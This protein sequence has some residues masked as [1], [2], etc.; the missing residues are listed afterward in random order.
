MGERRRERRGSYAILYGVSGWMLLGFGALAID[1]GMI[2]LAQSQSQDVADAASQGALLALRATGDAAKATTIA[3]AVAA[4]NRVSG[5]APTLQ[6]IRFGVWQDGAF[7]EDDER[8]NAVQVE[9]GR[10]I[11]LALSR[12]WGYSTFPVSRSSTSAARTLEVIL[13]MDI[14]NSWSQ[15][16]FSNARLA[17]LE[18]YDT[19]AN[20]AGPEDRIGM[21]LFSGQ[22]GVEYTP[23]YTIPEA[24]A[25]GVRYDWSVLRTASK[26]GTPSTNSNGCNVYTGASTND[27]S[28]PAGGCFPQMWREYADESGTDHTTGLEMAKLMFEEQ[29]DPSVYRALVLLTDGEPNG[30]GAHAQRAAAGFVDDRWR[31]YKTN[32]RRNT[33]AVISESQSLAETMQ[34]ELDV[35]IWAISFVASASWMNNVIQGD[36]Y[37]VQTS[38]SNALAGIFEDIAEGLPVAVVQ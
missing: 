3:E 29:D 19:I 1:I 32:I 8:P 7:S 17:A 9:V 12:I 36:G 15:A 23:L 10:P 34:E 14:T 27:F 13:V 25:S 37:F 30:T 2:R 26:A 11:D 35:N 24:E 28:S 4:N 18:F 31:W 16:N 6:T 5:A 38:S 33:S 22:Y 21:V 20:A